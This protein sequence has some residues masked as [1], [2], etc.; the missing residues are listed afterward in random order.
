MS[1]KK[2]IAI[3]L[4][5]MVI[6]AGV[7]FYVSG[8]NFGFA[9]A[10]QLEALRIK[11]EKFIN[12]KMVTSGTNATVKSIVEENGMY[13]ILVNVGSQELPAYISKDGKLFFPQ[14]VSME[15]TASGNPAASTQSAGQEAS[16]ADKPSVELFVMSYCPYGLQA[17]KGILPVVNL[18]GD[19]INFQL[20][21]VDYAMHGEKE[22][23]ENLRQ[24]CIQKSA[25]KKLTSYLDCFTKQ[26]DA[27]ACLATA[28]IDSSLQASCVSQADA[29]FKI[30]AK[31]ADKSQWQGT[32]PPFDADKND[33]LKYGVSGSPTLVING[34][35]VRASRAPQSLL[36]L[37]CSAFT[38]APSECQQ[39]LSTSAPSAGFG[40][41]TG[42]GANAECG[43]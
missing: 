9:S 30:K 11:A 33:N 16:K 3:S 27:A 40:E 24:Y 32:Y 19:K 37:I 39:K 14:T 22:I 38:S 6:L 13:K 23:D 31:A 1:D 4:G 36:T 18:L 7:Y 26:G 10:K 15:D 35:I 8:G 20:K 29:Q 41:G 12:E 25:P 34:E 42:S 21:F 2:I 17:Q 43:S 5:L 28:K